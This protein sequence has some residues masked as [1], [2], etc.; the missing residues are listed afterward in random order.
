MSRTNSESICP[1]YV[2]NERPHGTPDFGFFKRGHPW[3]CIIVPSGAITA[4]QEIQE[5]EGCTGPSS[6]RRNVQSAGRSGGTFD[7]ETYP[8]RILQVKWDDGDWQAE[9]SENL[10][11]RACVP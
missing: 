10:C 8:R 1:T 5:Y 9:Q 2:E 7:P 6:R 3:H 11:D 4:P